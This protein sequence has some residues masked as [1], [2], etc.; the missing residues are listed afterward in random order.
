MPQPPQGSRRSSN[1]S[2]MDRRTFLGATAAAAT[3]AGTWLPG[4]LAAA[5]PAKRGDRRPKIAAV[6]TEFRFRSHTYNIL[7]NFFQPYLFRGKLVDPGCDVVA[8]YADQFPDND[9]AREVAK[10]LQI[11]LYDTIEGAVC[12]GGDTL[13][14]DG[15]LLIGEHGDYPN[16]E[17]GQKMYPR[18]EF[19]DQI[20][21]PMRRA[22]RGVPI[23]NDKHLSYRWDWAKQMYD[24]A[25]ELKVPMLAGSSVPL[26]ERRPMIDV[27]PGSKITE[28]VVVHGGGLES[29]DFHGLEVLQSLV[30]GRA[31]GETGIS[32]V[33][34][35]SGEEYVKAYRTGLFSRELLEAALA[36]EQS[37]GVQRQK[38]PRVGGKPL[39]ISDAAN[40]GNHVLLVTYRDGLKA[41]VVKHGSSS[42][43]WDAALRIEGHKGP[44]AT[45]IYNGPWGNRCLFKALS[46]AIQH[47]FITGEPPYPVERTLMVSG[48]LEA[49][50]KSHAAGGKAWRTPYLEF[51]YKAKDFGPFRENGASWK[52]ITADTPQPTGFEPGDGRLFG[53]FHPN[54][55]GN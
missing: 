8:F 34:L 17:L 12:R 11:P 37:I 22:G 23:F 44:L 51:A 7:E 43:R 9:M 26:G 15:V 30:E 27:P 16:N 45:A 53:T 3:L 24:T 33:Q 54:M 38:R 41:A 52:L 1:H 48:A 49:A 21:A 50:I 36:A 4:S 6:F 14:V 2:Q 35:L 20:V 32:Q 47:L 5:E 55:I 31:G 46:H 42:D 25:Q 40:P 10:R 19:F 18:K 13:A 39:P 29:Y 28:A